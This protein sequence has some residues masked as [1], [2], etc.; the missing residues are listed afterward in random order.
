MSPTYRLILHDHITYLVREQNKPTTGVKVGQS[1]INVCIYPTCLEDVCCND[2][3]IMLMTVLVRLKL[4][5]RI[6]TPMTAILYV[7]RQVY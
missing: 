3:M 1:T 7:I 6:C 4:C 5:Y 2:V